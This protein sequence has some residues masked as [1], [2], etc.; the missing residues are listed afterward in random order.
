[1]IS[2]S[3]RVVVGYPAKF[4][5]DQPQATGVEYSLDFRSEVGAQI[6]GGT[7]KVGF[8]LF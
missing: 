4:E 3:W 5:K 7:P 6:I 2:A 8:E 1:M